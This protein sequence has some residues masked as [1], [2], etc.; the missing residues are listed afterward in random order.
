MA[1]AHICMSCGFDLARIRPVR[2]PHYGLMIVRCPRCTRAAVRQ[3]HPLL[4]RWKQIRR[5]DWSLTMI[6]LQLVIA[7]VVGLLTLVNVPAIVTE[8]IPNIPN[9]IN[10]VLVYWLS[11]A[12]CGLA[13]CTGA[14]L[15]A[16][17]SH[18][19]IWKVWL[20]CRPSWLDCCC[21]AP[22]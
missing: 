7:G 6:V 21:C 5:V 17:F 1:I 2:E 12:A 8:V 19:R 16:G 22:S 11:L 15:T 3:L 14:W 9:R 4:R 18:L 13:A 20:G 10:H